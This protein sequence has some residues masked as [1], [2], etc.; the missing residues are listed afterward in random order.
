MVSIDAFVQGV[1]RF[2]RLGPTASEFAE[3]VNYVLIQ[4]KETEMTESTASSNQMT[5]YDE[6]KDIKAHIADFAKRVTN[7]ARRKAYGSPEQNFERI[8]RFWNDYLKNK[9]A[10][11][12]DIINPTDVSLM[13]VLMKIARISESPDHLDSY[14]DLVGYTLTAAE[15]QGIEVP[16]ESE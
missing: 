9:G 7:G 15:T 2:A 13:M 3:A 12:V 11:T 5:E 16:E 8:A 4:T 14:R 10:I 1:K 6:E